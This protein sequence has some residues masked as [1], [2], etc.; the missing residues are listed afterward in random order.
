M[1]WLEAKVVFESESRSL[2]GE[3]IGNIFFDLG[4]KGVVEIDPEL[5]PEQG[6]GTNAL[7]PASQPALMGYLAD[8]EHL[9]GQCRKLEQ[10]LTQ[11]RQTIDLRY[12]I[13][14][15]RLDEEDWAKQGVGVSL[16]YRFSRFPLP[17]GMSYTY[18]LDDE[19]GQISF[20]LGGMF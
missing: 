14:Y 9:P 2:A 10:A 16:A 8:T 20:A 3:L 15:R 1:Q 17:L 12:V 7:K 4:L 6:G 13:T 11:L 18:C 5:A 19:D